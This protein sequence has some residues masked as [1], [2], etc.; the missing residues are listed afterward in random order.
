M[1][2]VIL[3]DD[4]RIVP[5][6]TRTYGY[7]HVT[8]PGDAGR[9][10]RLPALL[11]AAVPIEFALELAFSSR[12][13]R[14]TGDRGSARGVIAGGLSAGAPLAGCCSSS[15]VSRCDRAVDVYY[16]ELRLPSRR[17]SSR[18]TGSARTR[19]SRA[20]GRRARARRAA[21]LRGDRPQ[22]EPEATLTGAASSSRS[23]L[24]A[25]ARRP[26]LRSRTA[27]NRALREKAAL[28]E[29]RRGTP[30]AAPWSTSARIAGRVARRGRPRAERHD[31]AGDRRAPADADAPGARG[32]AFGAIETAGREA[33]DELR[34]LLGKLRRE[35]A[36]LAGAAAVL[37][38]R[39]LARAAHDRGRPAGHAARRGRR[40]PGRPA[41]TS[42][43]TA[44]SRRRSPRRSSTAAPAAPTCGC[45]SPPTRS[46]SVVRDDGAAG[47]GGAAADGRPRARRAA[48]RPPERGPRRSGGHAV[49][50]TLPLDAVACAAE[51]AARRA[52]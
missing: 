34:R 23:I 20:P 30:P 51:P 33:L 5:A 50:A 13:T 17:R 39:A 9:F 38:P 3:A 46:R 52:S 24:G 21:R 1:T 26:L 45:A 49:R 43:P 40:R 42:P 35:D 4:A 10:R 32:V 6:R 8:L 28:L 11:A 31:R 14:R 15:A 7:P 29:R 48:R 37:A 47:D 12:R 25:R 19:P 44:S 18:R 41:S 27:L 22:D 2:R 16:D 36:E